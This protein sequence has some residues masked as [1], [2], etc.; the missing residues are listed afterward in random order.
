MTRNGPSFKTSNPQNNR[1]IMNQYSWRLLLPFLCLAVA[2]GLSLASTIAD[3]LS[4]ELTATGNILIMGTKAEPLEVRQDVSETSRGSWRR[5]KEQPH[6][7]QASGAEVTRNSTYNFPDGS[8]VD[9]TLT[10][11][12]EGRTVFVDASWDTDSTAPGFAKSDLWIPESVAEDLIVTIDGKECFRDMELLGGAYSTP[13]E[14]V[15]TLASTGQ[16]L[17]IMRG[18]IAKFTPILSSRQAEPWLVFR[19]WSLDNPKDSTI[20]DTTK[21]SWSIDFPEK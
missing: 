9:H 15:G 16:T 4:L 18:E 21:Q 14:I 8:L 20:S 6:F 11:R 7:M 5:A 13:Q 2:S 19:L 10:A 17:F 3:S 12:V 1:L